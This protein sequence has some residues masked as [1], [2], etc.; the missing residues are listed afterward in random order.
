MNQEL[1][2]R[3]NTACIFFIIFILYDTLAG[4]SPVKIELAGNYTNDSVQLAIESRMLFSNISER[5]IP[6]LDRL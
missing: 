6:W 5:K 4:N 1:V 3:S 2:Y